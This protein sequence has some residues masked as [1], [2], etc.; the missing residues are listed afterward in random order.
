MF[1]GLFRPTL[2][3]IDLLQSFVPIPASRTTR[4]PFPKG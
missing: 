1:A 4:K 3:E 2:A